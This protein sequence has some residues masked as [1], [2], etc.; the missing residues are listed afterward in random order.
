MSFNKSINLKRI[1]TW[2]FAGATVSGLLSSCQKVIEIDT[3]NA[4]EKYVVEGVVTD[5][6]DKSFVKL[7]TTKNI[8]ENND[9]PPVTGATVL[10][11]DNSG[12]NIILSET[13]PGT[14]TAPAL[15]GSPGKTY[16]LDVTVNGEKFTAT[17]TMPQKINLD[18]LFISDEILFGETRKLAN[19][20]YQD[21]A[22]KGQCYRYVQYVNGKKNKPIFVNN[23]DYSD[24]KY[25]QSKL[26]YLVDEDENPEEEIKSGDTLTI[27]M[28]CI[29]PAVYKYWYSVFQS[30]TGSS[31]SASPANP[32]TN[33]KGGALGYF[34]AHTLQTRT[35][36][37]P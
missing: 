6:A 34:S 9:F 10:I 37:V 25:V 2:C 29:D 17:S 5:E 30:A 15:V 35:V 3:R 27:D 24:G 1:F 8:T 31:Q 4:E 20:A 33:I 21:P 26:W 32:V 12:N 11:N 36:V 22:G 28:L 13:S 7:S 19:I 18:T 16:S 14:Y 23:D